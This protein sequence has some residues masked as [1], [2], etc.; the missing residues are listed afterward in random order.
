MTTIKPSFFSDILNDNP[1]ALS[2]RA[3][4][5]IVEL[6][7]DKAVLTARGMALE[8]YSELGFCEL[9][10]AEVPR[11]MK[12]KYWGG[13]EFDRLYDSFSQVVWNVTWKEHQ[14]QVFQIEW[15]SS[16]GQ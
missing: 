3:E 10:S 8:R 7:E 6:A 9:E 15:T 13:E 11:A 12:F 16:C 4:L 2:V 14:F 1:A 5:A